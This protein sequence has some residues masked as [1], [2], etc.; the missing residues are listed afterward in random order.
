MLRAVHFRVGHVNLVPRP[1]AMI[2]RM[3][4]NLGPRFIWWD[5]FNPP[6]NCIRNLL[7][8]SGLVQVSDR[9]G[10]GRKK[11]LKANPEALNSFLNLPYSNTQKAFL[12]T[13]RQTL[14]IVGMPWASCLIASRQSCSSF[15]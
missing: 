8:L 14:I 5:L 12:M 6:K 10:G 2:A 11:H 7:K 15:F 1:C 4:A 3:L 13:L 9:E